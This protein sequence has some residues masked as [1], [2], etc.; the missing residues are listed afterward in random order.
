MVCLTPCRLSTSIECHRLLV[1]S[2]HP[3]VSFAR[4]SPLTPEWHAHSRDRVQDSKSTNWLARAS[5]VPQR[6]LSVAH[7]RESS[8]CNAIVLS[9]PDSSAVLCTGVA[10]NSVSGPL[11]TDIPNA[12]LLVARSRNH[13][14]AVCAPRQAL[15][16]I[17]ML[18]GE[19]GVSG[20][21]IP[22]LDGIVARSGCQYVPCSWVEENL[23]DLSGVSGKLAQRGNIWHFLS[24]SIEAKALWNLPDEN[25]SVVGTRCND[26]VVERIPN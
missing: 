4:S 13:H 21:D 11:L 26:A 20:L 12:K 8:S 9:H 23:P 22:D 14:V 18:Q 25:L 2:N 19:W 15:H 7:L 1:V 5:N 17:A 16:D 10:S 3:L 6:H 24:I